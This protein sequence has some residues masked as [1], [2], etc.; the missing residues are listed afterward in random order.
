M[1]LSDKSNE[2]VLDK[3]E[4]Q[5]YE[6]LTGG[7]KYPTLPWRNE[8]LDPDLIFTI[9]VPS[10]EYIDRSRYLSIATYISSPSTALETAFSHAETKI[11]S[12]MTRQRENA[13]ETKIK[14]HLQKYLSRVAGRKKAGVF[15]EES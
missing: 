15:E 5:F 14:I 3:E 12:E 8:D 2:Q 6:M 10:K 11:L 1:R 4:H 13:D 7:L 9:K